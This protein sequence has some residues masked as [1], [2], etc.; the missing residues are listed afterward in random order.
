MTREPF[1]AAPGAVRAAVALSLPL[2]P[3]LTMVPSWVLPTL[4]VL[5]LL[6]LAITT[7][8][9]VA[10]ERM[11]VRHATL[12]LIAIIGAANALALGL[13]VHYLLA[14]GRASGGD[15]LVSA[16]TIWL[17]NVLVFALW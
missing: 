16:I 9:R 3:R 13:L 5:L 11:R 14:G 6:P 1:C 7:P 17:T 15:L 4:E 12:A 8:H 10:D 2:P